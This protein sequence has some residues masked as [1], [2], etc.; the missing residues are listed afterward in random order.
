M[1][2]YEDDPNNNIYNKITKI[3]GKNNRKKPC[4]R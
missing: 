2:D 3:Q 4:W 1:A